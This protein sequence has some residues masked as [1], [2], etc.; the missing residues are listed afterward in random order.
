MEGTGAGG[1]WLQGGLDSRERRG[2]D[3]GGGGGWG[4]GVG[5]DLRRVPEG[6]FSKCSNWKRKGLRGELGWKRRRG[7]EKRGLADGESGDLPG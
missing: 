6:G 5:L 3:V 1:M 4:G 2:E 7:E